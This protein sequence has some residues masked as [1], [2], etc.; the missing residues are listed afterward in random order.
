MPVQRLY[1]S[2]GE[3][4]PRVLRARVT[5][6]GRE[7]K[8]EYRIASRTNS[9]PSNSH[10]AKESRKTDTLAPCCRHVLYGVRRNLRHRGD[11]LGRR[12]RARDSGFIV[13][14]GAVVLADGVHDRRAVERVAP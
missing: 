9:L 5:L 7:K 14:A 13:L 4:A 1:S 11:H 2:K 3:L 10:H 12:L 6:G 8:I